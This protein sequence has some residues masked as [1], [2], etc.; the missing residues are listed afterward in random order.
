MRPQGAPVGMTVASDGA[1]WLVEDKNQTVIRIDSE[2]VERAVGPQP[3]DLRTAPQINELVGMVLGRS[4]SKKR[5]TQM[6]TALIERHCLGCHADFDLKPGM[7]EAQKDEAVLRS[8]GRTDGSIP[9]RR[10]PGGCTIGSG[11]RAPA[12]SCRQTARNC[13]PATQTT[14]AR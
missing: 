13:S 14:V 12:K 4:E 10:R 5:L 1:I 3:C 7:N 8:W 9:A 11:A 6:R 2:P